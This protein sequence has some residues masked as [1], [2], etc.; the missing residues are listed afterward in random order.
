MDQQ[1]LLDL[2]IVVFAVIFV[3]V[4]VLILS[5]KFGFSI[6][7]T[8]AAYEFYDTHEKPEI[9][10]LQIG[11]ASLDKQESEK[12]YALL[13]GIKLNPEAQVI[14]DKI[15]FDHKR[16]LCSTGLKRLTEIETDIRNTGGHNARPEFTPLKGAIS[17]V[18]LFGILAY[19]IWQIF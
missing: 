18:I 1:T 11:L 16:K 4:V 17:V 14:V 9:L 15:L 19:M 13:Y 10:K 2:S 12:A 5:K 3:F 6:S 7:P 8:I